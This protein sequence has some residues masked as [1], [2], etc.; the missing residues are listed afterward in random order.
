MS[1]PAIDPTEFTGK[2]AIVTGGSLGI[3]R[4][5]A[6]RLA[7][8]GASVVVN[9]RRPEHV[10]ETVAAIRAAGG[11][12]EGVA[13]DAGDAATSASLVQTAVE[14]FGGVDILVCSAGIQRYGTVIDTT[15]EMWDE[16]MTVNLKAMFLAAK[17]AIPEMR[18]RGGGAIA[19]VSSVQGLATQ[20]TVAAYSTSKAA[21]IGLARAM[22]VDHAAENIRV[23]AVCPASVET[24]MLR[25]AAELHKGDSTGS[26]TIASWGGMHPLGRVGQP[27]EVAELIAFLVSPRASFIT[28]A[29]IKIDGGMM[30]ELGVVLPEKS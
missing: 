21:I 3:G 23:N 4:A 15:E 29:E 18:K 2:V 22:A 20:K 10:E 1:V 14:R 27:D 24:P 30:A 28:G 26:A 19:L 11:T 16:V 9:G 5:A 13:G 25:E 7:L 8:G 12:A 17:N 6:G